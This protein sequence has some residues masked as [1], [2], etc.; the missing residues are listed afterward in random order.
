MNTE[1]DSI[2]PPGYE[3]KDPD[4]FLAWAS[5]L[6]VRVA[7]TRLSNPSDVEEVVQEACLNILKQLS[8]GRWPENAG[9]WGWVTQIVINAIRTISRSR[10]QK[11]MLPLGD[12]VEAID[13]TGKITDPPD[14]LKQADEAKRTQPDN[15]VQ[16]ASSESRSKTKNPLPPKREKPSSEP[17]NELLRKE[18]REQLLECANKLPEKQGETFMLYLLNLEDLSMRECAEILGDPED[19]FKDRWYKALKK[20]GACLER[21]GFGPEYFR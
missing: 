8:R 6:A 16:Q 9:L 5:S 12:W 18:W 19:S 7:R 17:I 14:E 4:K 10:S 11:Q 20:V 2:L 1:N 3:K 21:S 15:H 13:D